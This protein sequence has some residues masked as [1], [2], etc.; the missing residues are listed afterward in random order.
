MLGCALVSFVGCRQCVVPGG[1][2]LPLALLATTGLVSVGSTVFYLLLRS[3]AGGARGGAIANKAAANEDPHRCGDS[4]SSSS[5]V[6][7]SAEVTCGGAVSSGGACVGA[8][9]CTSRPH[10]RHTCHGDT[11]IYH[12]VIAW[13]SSL[14]AAVHRCRR[15]S[16]LP[17]VLPAPIDRV[18]RGSRWPDR[19]TVYMYVCCTRRS[20]P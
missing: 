12:C 10:S 14:W 8:I 7:V 1:M 16:S 18:P 13:R 9:Y 15:S 5:S 6:K 17:D 3:A 2:R 20:P 19:Q 4:S 11:Y